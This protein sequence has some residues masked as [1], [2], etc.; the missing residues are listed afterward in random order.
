MAVRCLMVLGKGAAARH[1][2]RTAVR[3]RRFLQSLVGT[4]VRV[5]V[6]FLGHCHI[7]PLSLRLTPQN[8]KICSFFVFLQII[9]LYYKYPHATDCY[10]IE[11][12]VMVVEFGP[13]YWMH[14]SVFQTTKLQHK[15]RFKI[16]MPYIHY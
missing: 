7:P 15:R 2:V 8:G 12:L 10:E 5:L 11:F 14:N 4:K 16:N 13:M 9:F 6:K 1:R 3:Q